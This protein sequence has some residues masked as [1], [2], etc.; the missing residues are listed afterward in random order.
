MESLTKQNLLTK[1]IQ[2]QPIASGVL[3]WP[4]IKSPI[5]PEPQ[6][7]HRTRAAHELCSVPPSP[8]LSAFSRFSSLRLLQLTASAHNVSDCPRLSSAPCARSAA[9]P[10]WRAARAAFSC[11]FASRTAQPLVTTAWPSAATC[12]LPASTGWRAQRLW[13]TWA[14]TWR[15]GRFRAAALASAPRHTRRRPGAHRGIVCPR[16]SCRGAQQIAVAERRE[17]RWPR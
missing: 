14:G 9:S 15:C 3:L 8:A 7:A 13:P 11:A 17:A 4:L 6:P 12:S 2:Q 5:S 10:M 16:S 1:M